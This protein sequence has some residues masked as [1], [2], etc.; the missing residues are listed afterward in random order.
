MDTNHPGYKSIDFLLEVHSPNNGSFEH[1]MG[2][3][4]AR[5][6]VPIL[7]I[8]LE[9]D[10]ESEKVVSMTIQAPNLAGA[11]ACVGVDKPIPLTR[12][13]LKAAMSLLGVGSRDYRFAYLDIDGFSF[14]G[15]YRTLAIAW[16]KER[17]DMIWR[18][19][20]GKFDT[21]LSSQIYD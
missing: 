20:P 5:C 16:S 19:L 11:W 9:S 3:W 6:T 14:I 7:E 10:T 17:L 4:Y 15:G 21:R 18:S 1:P 2:M 12:D 8:G 13:S